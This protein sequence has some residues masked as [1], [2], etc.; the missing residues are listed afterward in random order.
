[1]EIGI[2]ILLNVTNPFN[3]SPIIFTVIINSQKLCIHEVSKVLQ[4]LSYLLK[5]FR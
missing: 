5:L 2:I 3:I 1:M 4:Y